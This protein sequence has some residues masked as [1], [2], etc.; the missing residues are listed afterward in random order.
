MPVFLIKSSHAQMYL[1]IDM[2]HSFSTNAHKEEHIVRNIGGGRSD[3]VASA[4]CA[5]C[6]SPAADVGSSSIVGAGMGYR[7]SPVWRADFTVALRKGYTLQGKS[8]IG[9]GFG[10]IDDGTS[11]SGV[12]PGVSAHL[13][14]WAYMLNGYYD[15]PVNGTWKPYIG[16]GLGYARNTVRGFTDPSSQRIG[17]LGQ[18]SNPQAQVASSSK[19]NLAWSLSLG[20]SHPITETF[21]LDIGYRYS[22][23]GKFESGARTQTSLAVPGC[24]PGNACAAVLRDE[25]TVGR[26]AG[27]LSAH[28]IVVGL[29]F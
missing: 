16:A 5:N 13:R 29:R 10:R 8:E 9:T 22:D 20:T 26:T 7:L 4:P 2:G 3:A 12:P 23:L 6:V 1:K 21:T 27:K 14:S 28:E 25:T 11:D 24:G 18:P 15:I 19:G 17:F